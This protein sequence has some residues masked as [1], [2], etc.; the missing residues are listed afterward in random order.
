MLVWSEFVRVCDDVRKS[1]M[2]RWSARAAMEVIRYENVVKRGNAAFKVNNNQQ[3]ALARAYLNMRR[4]YS[5]FELRDR[6][7]MN[8]EAA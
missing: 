1:G 3:A 8:S 4:C 5:F 6:H 7:Y 2:K